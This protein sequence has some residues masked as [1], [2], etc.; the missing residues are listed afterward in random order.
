MVIS[1]FINFV[2]AKNISNEM[3]HPD[4]VEYVMNNLK[5]LVNGNVYYLYDV[6]KI[7]EKK[8]YYKITGSYKNLI[9]DDVVVN[10]S[11][12]IFKSFNCCEELIEKLKKSGAK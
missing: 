4:F 6:K 9:T 5:Q 11:Y 12:R 3:N 8:K 1:F 7:K 2:T 10:T